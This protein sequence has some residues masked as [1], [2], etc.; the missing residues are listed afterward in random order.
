MSSEAIADEEILEEILADM[1][2]ETVVEGVYLWKKPWQ[3]LQCSH[4]PHI[5]IIIIEECGHKL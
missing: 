2:D 4:C 5:T 3:N 1:D